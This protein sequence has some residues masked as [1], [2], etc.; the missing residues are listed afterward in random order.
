MKFLVKINFYLFFFINIIFTSDCLEQWL[1][2]SINKKNNI[3][4]VDLLVNNSQVEFLKYKNNFKIKNKDY[5]LLL[6][7]NKTSKYIFKTNQ[8][9]IDFQDKKFKKY[10]NKFFNFSKNS[11]KFKYIKPN[12]YYLKTNKYLEEIS[13][14]FNNDCTVLDSVIVKD[15]NLNLSLNEIKFSY[16]SSNSFDS[17]FTLS[18]SNED[19]IKYDFRYEK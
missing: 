13:L 11:K 19:Y 7:D 15:K 8:L 9:F 6:D 12:K 16:F 10:I 17:L 1:D 2:A 3:I 5:L 18:L 4:Y 14:F